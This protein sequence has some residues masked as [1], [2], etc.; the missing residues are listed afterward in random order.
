MKTR[1]AASSYSAS[2]C[3]LNTGRLSKCTTPKRS[4][5]WNCGLGVK[6]LDQVM[7]CRLTAPP[8]R[9]RLRRHASPAVGGKWG[10]YGAKTAKG[11]Q[12][13]QS[14]AYPDP[15]LDSAWEFPSDRFR[16][17]SDFFF[18]SGQNDLVDVESLGN[19]HDLEHKT[20]PGLLVRANDQRQTAGRLFLAGEHG[21]KFGHAH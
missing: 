15:S 2:S 10:A 5:T 16:S 11:G 18:F 3:R 7:Y 21:R 8:V 9:Y 13:Q 20:V 1:L 4:G 19:L 17:R 14:R 12:S 6:V